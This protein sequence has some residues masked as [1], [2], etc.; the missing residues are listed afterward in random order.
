MAKIFLFYFILFDLIKTS[1]KTDQCTNL[2]E[3]NSSRNAKETFL[4]SFL[5]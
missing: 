2:D 3:A 5:F 4:L 1:D